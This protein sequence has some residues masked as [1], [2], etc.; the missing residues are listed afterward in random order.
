MPAHGTNDAHE[1]LLAK[2][3]ELDFVIR[4]DHSKLFLSDWNCEHPFVEHFLN[5]M[6]AAASEPER[7]APYMFYEDDQHIVSLVA[8]FHKEYEGVNLDNRTL[9]V[10]DGSTPFI[11]AFCEWAFEQGVTEFY[12]IPPL[13]YNF[14]YFSKLFGIPVR[15]VASR[16]P[17][18]VDF[19]LQLP[20][21]R[22]LL[23]LCDPVWYSGTAFRAEVVEDIRNWQE[24]TGSLIFVDGSFQYMKWGG[25]KGE[26]TSQ[27]LPDLT[28]RLV[29]PTK[30]VAIH[31]YRFSYL[32]VPAYARNQIRYIY[33][34][35]H[36]ATTADNIVFANTVMERLVEPEG[37]AKVIQHI[38]SVYTLLTNSRLLVDF[39]QP[40]CGYFMFAKTAS[41]DRIL[42]MDGDFFEQPRFRDFGR[43]NLLAP[44]TKKWLASGGVAV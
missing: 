22:V 33:A 40:D 5:G 6:P 18:E 26:C 10:G 4:S 23:I 15:P 14:Y 35:T 27:L 1:I 34:N 2:H 21:K 20:R 44:A 7:A 29:C 19:F 32:I 37:N 31:G 28:F 8:K 24:S 42:P 43:I 38:V 16:H 39:I 13:Y 36:G 12:Y 11:S 9:L 41:P 3:H 25:S 30:Q 17:F